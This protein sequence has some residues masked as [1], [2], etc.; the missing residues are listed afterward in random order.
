MPPPTTSTSN[1]SSARAAR[2]WAR[3]ITYASLSE[4]AARAHR[5]AA[6]P[7]AQCPAALRQK[8]PLGALVV[9][10]VAPVAMVVVMPGRRGRPAQ[11]LTP[12]AGV[13]AGGL[14]EAFLPERRLWRIAGE[15]GGNGGS[16]DRCV[17]TWAFGLRA[18][19]AKAHETGQDVVVRTLGR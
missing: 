6:N 3:A 18:A 1:S 4:R 15:E 7:R 8:K 9:V 19:F 14:R 10:L 2:A 12:R 17:N 16:G 13:S 5:A 11:P